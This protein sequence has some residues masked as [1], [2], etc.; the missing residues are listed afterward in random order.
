MAS[1]TSN[2]YLAVFS[3]TPKLTS[4][5]RS[6]SEYICCLSRRDA[7][8]YSRQGR[9]RV[10][11][12]DSGDNGRDDVRVSRSQS[13]RK[14]KRGDVHAREHAL[15]LYAAQ[16]F[17]A[18]QSHSADWAPIL[19]FI[20]A[21]APNSSCTAELQKFTQHKKDTTEHSG[22]RVTP[23]PSTAPKRRPT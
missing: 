9:R 4:L 23:H 12:A 5:C 11:A 2:A 19:C 16:P 3:G 14:F 6:S 20:P 15:R 18:H 22:L 17:T 8:S 13:K 7:N 1:L 10:K 21:A